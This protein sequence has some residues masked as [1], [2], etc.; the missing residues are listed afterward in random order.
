MC[1]RPVRR[2]IGI[3]PSTVASSDGLFTGALAVGL[4]NGPTDISQ[5]FS[6]GSFSLAAALGTNVLASTQGRLGLAV[7]QGLGNIAGNA[8][9][10][11]AGLSPTDNVNVAVNVLAR[12]GTGTNRTLA[13]GD[14]NLAANLGGD[15]TDTRDHIVQAFGLGNIAFNGR[16]DG[17]QVSAGNRTPLATDAGVPAPTPSTLGL[18]FNTL[19]NNN[20]STA[21]GP[22]AVAASVFGN[23]RNGVNR[24]L[25]TGPGIAL[26]RNRIG[27]SSAAVTTTATHTA[28]PLKR[29]GTT[30]AEAINKTVARVTKGLHPDDS[31]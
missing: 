6:V 31:E 23:G 22:L 3:G 28:A 17:N 20:T 15:S 2:A 19:G 24:V 30:V 5:A 12:S 21:I 11:Q 10:A 7:S 1:E 18:A 26:N 8:V 27:T 9:T 29:I 25:Q 4:R 16:G 13:V 14:G